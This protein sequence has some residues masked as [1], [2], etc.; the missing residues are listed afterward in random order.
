[1][2]HFVFH[3]ML[4]AWNVHDLIFYYLYNSNKNF[5]IYTFLDTSC[6]CSPHSVAV[7][8]AY[9]DDIPDHGGMDVQGNEIPFDNQRPGPSEQVL[10]DKHFSPKNTCSRVNTEI[11]DAIRKW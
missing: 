1:M 8:G 4:N 7:G 3:V 11:M 10:P 2:V 6:F 5:L 9:T